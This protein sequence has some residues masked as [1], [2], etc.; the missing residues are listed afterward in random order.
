ML[1]TPDPRERRGPARAAIAAA[2]AISPEDVLKRP[3]L[4]SD[5][6]S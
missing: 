3:A 6:V 2:T 1:H 5:D 4:A